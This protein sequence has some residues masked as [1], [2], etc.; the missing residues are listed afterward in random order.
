MAPI[1]DGR[2]G[3]AERAT[4]LAR[5]FNGAA[6]LKKAMAAFLEKMQVPPAGS[7]EE[8]RGWN[9]QAAT[10]ADVTEHAAHHY[11]RA[12]AREAAGD[13]EGAVLHYRRAFALE[14]AL[15]ADESDWPAWLADAV[16]ALSLI[17]I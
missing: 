3:G 5:H 8:R 6:I 14:R 2:R 11:L 1:R 9:L 13:C 7:I 17:H 15:D 12:C 10:D 4:A 16:D